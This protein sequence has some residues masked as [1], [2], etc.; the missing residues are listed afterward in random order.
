MLK[1]QKVRLY[2]TVAQIEI[3]ESHFGANRYIFNRMLALR[4]YAYSKFRKNVGRYELDKRLTK[5]KKRET[6]KWLKEIDS[7]SIQSTIANLDKAY[8]N[9]F[10]S[11]GFPRFKSVHDSRQSYQYPQRVKIEGSFVYLPKVGWVKAKGLRTHFLGKIKTV[12]VSREAGQYHAALLIDT[13][14][15][16]IVESHN[17]KTVGI[18]MGVALFVADSNGKKIKPIDLS[19]DIKT[20]KK[21]QQQL[22][23]KKKGSNN[24][25]KAKKRLSKQYLKVRNKRNDFLH[26]ISK[27]YSESQTVVVEDLKIKNMTKSARGTIEAPKKSAGKRGLN[28][29]I[30]QQGW[31]IFFDMLKYKIESRG[32]QLIKVNPAFTSQTCN[33]CNHISKENRLTQS[34]FK[35]SKCGHTD[36][37]DINAAKNILSAGLAA[38][39]ASQQV[40]A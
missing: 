33:K 30:L 29:S 39:N 28:N 34:K 4:K 40:A 21:R 38:V 18:D 19:R 37:A 5:L 32:G 1:A 20:L 3:I 15:T 31:G 7:Q 22:S 26:K 16:E 10:K 36:N 25:S 6:T 11:G 8:K 23:N 17:G 2:P 27:I 9:F 24:R 14:E 12:T 13:D 35:C